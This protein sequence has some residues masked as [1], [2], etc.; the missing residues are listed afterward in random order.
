VTF[1][2]GDPV[3]KNRLKPAWKKLGKLFLGQFK[4]VGKTLERLLIGMLFIVT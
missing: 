4:M 1:G 2:P 3:C